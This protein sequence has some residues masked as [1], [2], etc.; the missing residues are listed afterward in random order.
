MIEPFAATGW[1]PAVRVGADV[2]V[3]WGR[4]QQAL[5]LAHPGGRDGEPRALWPDYAEV[6]VKAGRI[7][8]AIDVLG[9]Y[10]RD[11]WVLR[12]LVRMTEGQGRD[13]RVLEVLAPIAAGFRTGRDGGW[14]LWKALTLQALVLE[15]SGQADE[16]IRCL[17]A[18]VAA[19]RYGPQ[20]TVEFYAELLARH[21]RVEELREL[22]T[23]PQQSSAVPAY[24]KALEDLGRAWHA[25]AFLRG[26]IATLEYPTRYEYQLLE[27]LARQGR[28]DEAVAAVAHTFDDLN[29][30]N[31]LQSAML[32]L[33]EHGHHARA[34]ALTEGRSAEFIEESEHWLPSNRWWLMGE[35]GQC[36][37][38]IAEV[39][40]MTDIEPPSPRDVDDRNATIG[41]LLAKDGREEEAIAYLRRCSGFWAS[42]ELAL[43]LVGQ[44]RCAEAI[45]AV[46]GVAAQRE[47]DRRVRDY[48]DAWR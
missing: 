4:I 23:G 14:G 5:E 37:E 35:T 40:A 25:E 26:L 18:T 30:S 48:W 1:R 45:A 43:V 6:L 20:N 17:G 44:G 19:G 46:P 47:E 22:A 15:R 33:A 8:E 2:L 29:D 3:Q 28:L 7:D 32:V 42:T 16:A 34:L 38:A 36:R 9:P 21:G 10:L 41:R 24:V 31:L 12:D 39:E 13:E 27:L 11:H